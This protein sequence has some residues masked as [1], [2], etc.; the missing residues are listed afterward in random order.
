MSEA[1]LY[2]REVACNSTTWSHPDEA[3][4]SCHG[5][6]WWNSEVD[7]WHKCPFHAPD[8]VH[9]EYYDTEED[10]RAEAEANLDEVPEVLVIA[11]ESSPPVGSDDDILF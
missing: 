9:P 8:A 3:V 5:R 2:Y 1:T 4:C 10:F 11:A 6:G 7:T